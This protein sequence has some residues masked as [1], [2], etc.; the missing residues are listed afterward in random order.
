MFFFMLNK[1]FYVSQNRSYTISNIFSYYNNF[2]TF[3]HARLTQAKRDNESCF[4]MR[5]AGVQRFIMTL[6]IHKTAMRD[7]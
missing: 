5:A 1:I 4:F 3:T 6:S 2:S 7:N